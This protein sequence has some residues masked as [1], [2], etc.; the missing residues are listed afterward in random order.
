MFTTATLLFKKKMFTTAPYS[1]LFPT[2]QPSLFP[3]KLLFHSCKTFFSPRGSS[4]HGM[5]VDIQHLYSLLL[6]S[7]MSYIIDLLCF[8]KGHRQKKEASLNSSLMEG[9]T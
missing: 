5:F 7:F 2:E 8:L 4:I 6:F 3:N 1:P 9:F